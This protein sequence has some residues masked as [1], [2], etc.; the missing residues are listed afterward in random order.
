MTN[1]LQDAAAEVA[2]QGEGDEVVWSAV[3][4]WATSKAIEWAKSKP[5][6][7]VLSHVDS[8][9]ANRVVSWLAAALVSMGFLF[10]FDGDTFTITGS[11]SGIVEGAGHAVRQVMFQE[12]AYKKFIQKSGGTT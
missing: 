1:F 4:A 11:I 5:W 9:R 12:I 10:S 2:H 3:T 7:P 6:I 8:E